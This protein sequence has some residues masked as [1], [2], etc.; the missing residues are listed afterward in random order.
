M[1]KMLDWLV[2]THPRYAQR[3]IGE[4]VGGLDGV[5]MNARLRGSASVVTL[6]ARRG[7]CDGEVFGA[8]AADDWGLG[9]D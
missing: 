6:G 4:I 7:V 5:A 8:G 3:T 2:R 1:A 9:E